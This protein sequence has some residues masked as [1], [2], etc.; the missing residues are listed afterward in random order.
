MRAACFAHL[1]ALP[2]AAVLLATLMAQ[3]QRIRLLPLRVIVTATAAIVSPFGIA[4]M[5]PVAL[6]A[7]NGSEVE[8]DINADR[9][10]CIS[11]AK[12]RGLDALPATTLFT[13]LDIGSHVLAYTHH[14]VVATGHH[15]NV[16]GM[17]SVLEGLIATPEQARML[18]SGTGASY[19]AFCKGENEVKHYKKRYPHSLIA[20][21]MVGNAPNWLQKVPMRPGETIQVYRIIPP[22]R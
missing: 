10:N 7:H 15:R 20:A 3:A 4:L 18:V 19:L 11:G 22:A 8:T 5:T 14:K 1:L 13:P 6:E 12:L 21:L 9:F 16:A 2:G 17:K